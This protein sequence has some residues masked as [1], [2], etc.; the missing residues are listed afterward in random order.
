MRTSTSYNPKGI[1]RPVNWQLYLSL[2][3]CRRHT[4]LTKHKTHKKQISMPSAGIETAIPANKR[5]QTRA[6]DRAVIDVWLYRCKF[7][8]KTLSRITANSSRNISYNPSSWPRSLTY[9]T[10]MLQGHP[11][12]FRF[13][14]KPGTQWIIQVVNYLF[15]LLVN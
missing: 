10:Q 15:C 3:V 6:L 12:N 4:C 7:T 11:I 5:P 1:S 8:R 14:H 13:S 2:S 9:L